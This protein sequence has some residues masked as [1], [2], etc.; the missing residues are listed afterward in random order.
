MHP[1]SKRNFG[2]EF[3]LNQKDAAITHTEQAAL[4]V[5]VKKGTKLD[6]TVTGWTTS[7]NNN[8]WHIKTDST[9]GKVGH[10]TDYGHE[11]ASPVLFGADGVKEVGVVAENIKAGEF[12]VN[13]NCG[14]H[15]H[16]EVADF[17][18]EQAGILLSYWMKVENWIL[19]MVPSHRSQ[20]KYCK[21]LTRRRILKRD[22]YH[23]PTVVWDAIKPKNTKPFD[24]SEKRFT[25]NSVHIANA[26]AT[27]GEYKKRTFELRIP[28]GTVE[29]EDAVFWIDLFISFVDCVKS[30]SPPSTLKTIVNFDEF[31]S[32]F[33][34][35]YDDTKLQIIKRL[36]QYARGGMSEKVAKL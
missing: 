25:L 23:E 16:A 1:K 21:P 19:H 36:K 24:N 2:V 13:N 17:N 15:V 4:Q 33:D 20:N 7:V 29:R 14:Y 6:V 3:E 27:K 18:I 34:H 5:A 12:K 30:K 31:L 26:E 10:G 8:Y 32:C 22:S 9:C 28:E 35:A 11:V